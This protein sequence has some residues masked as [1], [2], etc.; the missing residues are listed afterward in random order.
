MN[1]LWKKY[2][3]YRGVKSAIGRSASSRSTSSLKRGR[4]QSRLSRAPRSSSK[5]ADPTDAERFLG[6]VVYLGVMIPLVGCGFL[7]GIVILML[8]VGFIGA[9]MEACLGI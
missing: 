8:F 9:I 1:D 2:L 6:G 4:A 3:L 7:V 5:Q